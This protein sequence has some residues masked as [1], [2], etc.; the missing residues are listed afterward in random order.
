MPIAAIRRKTT[1]CSVSKPYP[2]K[3]AKKLLQLLIGYV[4]CPRRNPAAQPCAE[5]AL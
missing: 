3:L 5:M 4:A 1:N 2:P